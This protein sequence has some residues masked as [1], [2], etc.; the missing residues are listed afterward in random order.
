MNARMRSIHRKNRIR[1]TAAY[2]E[3]MAGYAENDRKRKELADLNH[4]IE[5]AKKRAELLAIQTKAKEME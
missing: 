4:Q 3:E 2:E 1:D 5:V